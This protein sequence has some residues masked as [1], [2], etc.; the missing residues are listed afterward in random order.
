MS[1]LVRMSFSIE[2]PLY[3]QLEKLV[4][5]AGYTNRSEYV[6]DMI[7]EQLVEREWD[8]DRE[9]LGTITIVYDHERRQLSE[10]LI[11]LQHRDHHAVLAATHVH[12]THHL[13][14]EVILVK[15]KASFVKDLADLMRQQ[16]GVLHAELSTTST[17]Q[18]LH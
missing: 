11:K 16:K 12:L 4:K 3:R 14:A 13:C 2:K 9:V 5:D 7:R 8:A 6:R 17:G 10:K 18:Q 15:A 1:E